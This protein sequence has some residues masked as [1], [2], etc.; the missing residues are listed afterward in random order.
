M[1]DSLSEKVIE[2]RNR[3]DAHVREMVE[4]HFNPET[5]SEFWLDYASKLDFDPRTEIG[6]YA[7]LKILDHFEDTW[8]RGAPSQF[9]NFRKRVVHF[10]S[11]GSCNSARFHSRPPSVLISTRV[12][13]P[14][15]LHATPVI[16]C[17]PV[18]FNTAGY[19]G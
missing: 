11:T 10:G 12:M 9:H 7:D 19:A 1:R 18:P 14:R 4:W 8:L 13:L 5:G 16:S 6:G 3:L 2:A 15:P 17:H